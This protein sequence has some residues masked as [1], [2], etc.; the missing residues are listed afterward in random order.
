MKIKFQ[1]NISLANFSTFK[2]GGKIKYFLKAKNEKEIVE[3]IKWAKEEKLS[4]FILGGGSNILFSDKK[5]KGLV[6]KIENCRLQIVD[7]KI[8]AEAGVPLQKLVFESVKKGLSG[9][10]F[11]AGIPGTLGGAIRGN[12]GAFGGEMKNVVE[13]VRV[14]RVKNKEFK[15]EELKNDECEFGYRE[16][17]FKKKKNW[18][19]LSA[20]LKLKKGKKKEIEKEIKEILKKRKERQPLDFPSAGSVF[21][22]VPLEKV[23]KEIQEIFKDKIKREPFPCL[24]AG[25]LIEAVG[26]KG[27]Q[28]GGAKI[29]EKHANFILNVKNAKAKDVLKLIN[30]I[31]KKVKEK[32]KIKLKE[33]IEIVRF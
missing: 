24:P 17:I 23:P 13:K 9:L 32:F 1:K 5:F 21:K 11:A 6:I 28:I 30:L 4:F 12:A 10:E 7:C 19:I 18:I 2:I 16:S 8:V 26:L 15:I 3:A 25:A 33:E 14:L 20:I 22:N 27:Y 31:K 29:S